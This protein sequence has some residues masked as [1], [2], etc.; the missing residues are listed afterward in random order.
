[1]I[2]QHWLLPKIIA[3]HCSYDKYKQ[4]SKLDYHSLLTCNLSLLT[5]GA[6]G[7]VYLISV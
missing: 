2:E 6:A 1:M 7:T 3:G 4:V 5:C